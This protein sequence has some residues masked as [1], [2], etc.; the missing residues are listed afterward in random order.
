[1]RR[2]WMSVR[3][4]V[5]SPSGRVAVVTGAGAGLGRAIAATFAEFGARVA[6]WERDAETA[7]SAAAAAGWYHADGHY[8]LGPM[9]GSTTPNRRTP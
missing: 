2:R 8:A 7:E 1:M 5:L 4:D 6:I 3:H 9:S